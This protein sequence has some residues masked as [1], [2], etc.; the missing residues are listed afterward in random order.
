MYHEPKSVLSANL[1]HIPKNVK[2]KS[3]LNTKKRRRKKTTVANERVYFFALNK[4]PF[5]EINIK[6]IAISLCVLFHKLTAFTV[7]GMVFIISYCPQE[8]NLSFFVVVVQCKKRKNSIVVAAV[9][10][11]N[12][13]QQQQ[14][15]CEKKILSNTQALLLKNG[16]NCR[17]EKNYA[18]I[19]ARCTV[20]SGKRK[21]NESLNFSSVQKSTLCLFHTRCSSPLICVRLY[22]M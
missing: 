7:F 1:L 20:L 18:E 5:T 8:T 16:A 9:N 10:R 19:K 17:V 3:K 21:K 12:W 14:K 13:Q 11:F 2:V 6:K 15:Q 22:R 4:K